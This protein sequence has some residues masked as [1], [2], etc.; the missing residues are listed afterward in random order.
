VIEGYPNKR[1]NDGETIGLALGGGGARGFG[2]IPVFRALEELGLKPGCVTGTSI[3]ALMGAGFCAGMDSHDMEEYCLSSFGSLSKIISRF[4][5]IRPKNL[6]EWKRRGVRLAQFQIGEIFPSFLPEIIP[7]TFEDL[8]IPLGV[9]AADIISG[10]M[11]VI[12]EGDLPLGLAASAALPGVFAPV[13]YGERLLV[14]GGV[15]NPVPV[16]CFSMP[17]DMTIGVDITGFEAGVFATRSPSLI[18]S[19]L[20]ATMLS[21]RALTAERLKTHKTDLMLYPPVEGIYVL[22]FIKT[23]EIMTHVLGFKEAAKHAIAD[24]MTARNKG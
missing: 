18:E 19:L 24:M 23:R 2:H 3:G 13:P 9:V 15:C 8:S 7:A 12:R 10:E 11:V 16:D 5:R 22:D 4:W 14:D 6:S 1:T 20:V 17:V 21:Q